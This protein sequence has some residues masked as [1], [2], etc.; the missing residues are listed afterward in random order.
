[1]LLNYSNHP[2]NKWGENQLTSA[3]QKFGEIIDIPFPYIDPH[4]DTAKVRQLAESELLRIKIMYSKAI[5][6]MGEL[7]F[8]HIFVELCRDIG[9]PC[10][11]STTERVVEEVDGKKVSVF[12]FVAFRNYY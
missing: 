11:A 6:I 1:M 2:S 10:V 8:V 12:R 7:T 4:W 9:I 5:H 3:R